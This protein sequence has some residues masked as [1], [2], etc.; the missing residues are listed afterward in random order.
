MAF[1]FDTEGFL[2][3]RRNELEASI[4]VAH[5]DLLE[6]ARQIFRD[7]HELLFNADIRNRDIRAILVATLFMRAL[8]HYQATFILL[9]MGLVS[10]AKVTLRALMETVFT[11]R[12]VALSQEAL[13]AFITDDLLQ[14]RKL[15][16]KVRQHDHPNLEDAR[17]AIT[18][19]LIREIE[20]Q[21]E[22]FEAK[23][24]RTKELSKLAGM[25][26]W[27]TGPYA[28]LSKATHTHVRELEDYLR[29]DD[30]DEV[31]QFIYG[32]SMEETPHLTLTAAHAV[33][34]AASAFDMKFGLVFGPKGDEH[35]KFVECRLGAL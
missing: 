13:R 20:G 33:L 26:D 34:I 4:A 8:E 28:V 27:Y 21:I 35:I 30:A 31:R 17:E 12:A 9:S 10:P 7:C 3:T 5:G 24:L 29:T 25:H 1:E 15:I 23:P 16:N 22:A 18:D 2:S 14:R 19:E 11:I 32:P 6:R